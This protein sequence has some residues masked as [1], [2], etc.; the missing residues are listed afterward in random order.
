MIIFERIKMRNFFSIGN[1]PIEIILNSHKK[2]LACGKNGSSKSVS[3]LDSIC[4]ALFGKPFRKSNKPS[5]VNSINKGNCVVEVDFTINT[6]R[7]KIIRGIKPTIFE[8]YCNDKLINQDS[9]IKDYQEYLERYILKTNFKSFTSV[10]ILGSARYTPFMSLSA[11]DR[12]SIIE[13]LLD[14]EVF[15]IMNTLLKDKLSK[16]KDSLTSLTYNIQIIK[17]KITLQKQHLKQN[18]KSVK[19]QIKNKES[20]I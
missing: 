9:N 2:T 10:V 13:E 8:I 12:R 11:A 1:T 15:S 7:Y 20:E 3:L 19:D 5:V 17:E 14:I 18:K 6:K 4:F 16:I